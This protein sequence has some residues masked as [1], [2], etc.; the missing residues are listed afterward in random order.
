MVCVIKTTNHQIWLSFFIMQWIP[1]ISTHGKKID[2]ILSHCG[3]ALCKKYIFFYCTRCSTWQW[4]APPGSRYITG[5]VVFLSYQFPS[6]GPS[7]TY[8]SGRSSLDSRLR[9]FWDILPCTNIQY[10]YENTVS[11]IC[12]HNLLLFL[13]KNKVMH[14]VLFFFLY[15]VTNDK[16][17][18]PATTLNNSIRVGERIA[19]K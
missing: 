19:W 3:N 18:E 1:C 17:G 10:T 6:F 14:K 5:V 16:W 7:K 11:T 8:E 13:C 12:E 9:T 15:L 2:K 4:S